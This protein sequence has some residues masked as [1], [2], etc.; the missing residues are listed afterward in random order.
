MSLRNPGRARGGEASAEPGTC[1]ILRLTLAAFRRP[2][3]WS[4]KTADLNSTG[5]C[6]MDREATARNLQLALLAI[7]QQLI[8]AEDLARALGAWLG[9]PATPLAEILVRQQLLSPSQRARID[10]FVNEQAAHAAH[11]VEGADAVHDAEQRDAEQREDEDDDED[12]NELLGGA[13][14]PGSTMDYCIETRWCAVLSL[15]I[16]NISLAE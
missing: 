15:M 6:R 5:P 7:E 3:G 9:D 14:P 1:T 12:E 10:A 11:G 13:G 4:A 8:G 16:Q 2:R